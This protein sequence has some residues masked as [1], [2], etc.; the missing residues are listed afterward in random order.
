V[1]FT[2]PDAYN[3][4]RFGNFVEPR[5]SRLTYIIVQALLLLLL[6]LSTTVVIDEIETNSF[7][8][9]RGKKKTKR[10]NNDKPQ[11]QSRRKG[12]CVYVCVYT[13][14]G[15]LYRFSPS[16]RSAPRPWARGR[17]LAHLY[18]SPLYRTYL[19]AKHRH[20]IIITRIIQYDRRE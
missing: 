2:H 3:V 12:W 13:L 19:T 5:V 18:T 15:Q 17:K 6:L 4:G 14:N 16:T 10:K 7:G 9:Q 8:R 1:K 11:T 20:G